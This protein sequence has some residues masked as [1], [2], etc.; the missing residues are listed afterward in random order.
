MKIERT[1]RAA[2]ASTTARGGYPRRVED[3]PKRPADEVSAVA[4]VMGIPEGE[5]TPRVR[6]AIMALMGEVE[7]LRREL[8]QTRNRLE[9]AEKDADQDH[10]LPL[11]NRRAFVRE[12]TRSIGL[13]SRYGTPSSLVYFDLDDFKEVN[14]THGHAAG[15]AVLAHFA[16]T[17]LEH[18]RDSDIVGRIGGDEFAVIL[19]HATQLLAHRKAAVL[20]E[21]LSGSPAQWQGRHIP[22]G[23]SYGTFELLP[24]ESADVAIA[25]ADEAM[26][27]HKKAAAGGR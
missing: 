17:L 4:S 14:D 19:T 24:G 5:F 6:D 12:V 20:A 9:A 15:D 2:A 25:R 27:A 23:F 16:A 1:G 8:E 10:L 7:T 26:Y 21:T 22:V 11:L 3:A 18:T 13:A